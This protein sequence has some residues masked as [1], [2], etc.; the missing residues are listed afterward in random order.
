MGLK[1]KWFRR[2]ITFEGI[3]S[4][5]ERNI[6]KKEHSTGITVIGVYRRSVNYEDYVEPTRSS[7]WEPPNQPIATTTIRKP[8]TSTT[9]GSPTTSANKSSVIG[10][11]R[12]IDK[13]TPTASATT[14]AKGLYNGRIDTPP[15]PS[16]S[17]PQPP[18]RRGIPKTKSTPNISTIE[19]QSTSV[20][21]HRLEPVTRSIEVLNEDIWPVTNKHSPTTPS[22]RSRGVTH[23]STHQEDK[24]NYAREERLDDTFEQASSKS[25]SPT[26]VTKKLLN[27]PSTSVKAVYNQND[28][29]KGN[30]ISRQPEFFNEI[31]EKVNDLALAARSPD[32]SRQ[33]KAILQTHSDL[34]IQD[35]W[36]PHDEEE[37]FDDIFE[38]VKT[39]PRLPTEC[40][41]PSKFNPVI[42]STS[43]TSLEDIF[44]PRT[45]EIPLIDIDPISANPDKDPSDDAKPLKSILKKRAPAPPSQPLEPPNP[46]IPSVVPIPPPRSIRKEAP[47]PNKSNTSDDESDDYLNWNL[48]ERH[49]SSINHT[50]AGQVDP[51]ILRN[52][53]SSLQQS[54]VA[55]SQFA[56][57]RAIEEAAPRTLRGMRNQQQQ[58]V[59]QSTSDGLFL[60][61]HA[62]SARDSGSNLSEASA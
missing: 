20:S 60:G 17:P 53:P 9:I 44:E 6:R 43:T 26:K 32:S 5:P 23:S 33:N 30:D 49:R 57:S 7:Y 48:V 31:L 8:T 35:P 61:I 54:T 36:Q 4:A 22:P 51:D 50:V 40:S 10:T 52:V 16:Y 58:D 41:S 24:L 46:L 19:H 42:A 62:R 56:N 45:P 13:I 37:T 47:A 14:A 55:R 29:P 1:L 59:Q 38:K 21:T 12:A 18:A 39:K 2:R 15:Q 27:E 34:A 3:P 28:S 11:K 25:R